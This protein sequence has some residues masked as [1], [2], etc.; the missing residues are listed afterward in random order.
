MS[1]VRRKYSEEDKL[2]AVKP[3]YVEDGSFRNDI[4]TPN[5]SSVYIIAYICINTYMIST[6]NCFWL[7]ITHNMPRNKRIGCALFLNYRYCILRKRLSR[8]YSGY[9]Y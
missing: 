3:S 6:G 8:T 4:K 9:L 1:L 5:N 7:G 2:N